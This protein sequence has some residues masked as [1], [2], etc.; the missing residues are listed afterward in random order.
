MYLVNRLTFHPSTN[1]EAAPRCPSTVCE[2]WKR[3]VGRKRDWAPPPSTGFAEPFW[4][5]KKCF[6]NDYVFYMDMYIH[7]YTYVFFR[8]MYIQIYV[9]VFK[10]TWT[11]L[12]SV[13]KSYRDP[14]FNIQ[15]NVA[16]IKPGGSRWRLSVR[17]ANPLVLGTKLVGLSPILW[18]SIGLGEALVRST[19]L[20]TSSCFRVRAGC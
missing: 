16:Q 8:F 4:G 13:Q 11:S 20:K 9:C 5:C 14:F 17:G 12:V 6:I 1:S 15:S 3:G 2:W 18:S 10:H 7:E 19:W